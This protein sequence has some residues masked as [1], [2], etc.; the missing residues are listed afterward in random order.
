MPTTMDVVASMG[1]RLALA[2]WRFNHPKA[3][4]IRFGNDNAL[5]TT[6]PRWN[7]VT[8][9]RASSEQGPSAKGRHV[10]LEAG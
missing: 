10:A 1:V 9:Q 3:G 6:Q 7:L 2:G 8:E 4:R 5:G